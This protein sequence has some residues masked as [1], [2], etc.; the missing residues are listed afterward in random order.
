MHRGIRTVT[1][2]L[3]CLL[4]A[5]P[6]SSPVVEGKARQPRVAVFEL[7]LRNVKLKASM[8]GILRDYLADQVAQTG[9]YRVVP[10]DKTRAALNREQIQTKGLCFAKSCQIRIGRALAADRSLSTRVMRIGRNCTVSATLYN[11]ET[12]VTEKGASAKGGCG[13][14]A[15]Q[16][17]I[18]TVV[19][20]LTVKARTPSILQEQPPP[21]P[22]S[23]LRKGKDNREKNKE[24]GRLV[25]EGTPSGALIKLEGPSAFKGPANG[26]LPNDWSQI[27]PGSYKITV[28]AKGFNKFEA[29]S[30]VK[31][32]RTSVV[33]AQ[34]ARA[35]ETN[36]GETHTKTD[37][38]PARWTP[39]LIHK[40]KVRE[41]QVGKFTQS[42]DDEFILVTDQRE[43][44]QVTLEIVRVRNKQSTQIWQST[45]RGVLILPWHI[46][47][48]GQGNKM[49]FS[50]EHSNNAP[51]QIYSIKGEK[52]TKKKPMLTNWGRIVQSIQVQSKP[53]LL[54]HHNSS[55]IGCYYRRFNKWA[56]EY[57]K[58]PLFGRIPGPKKQTRDGPFWESILLA[59]IIP[60][61]N[62]KQIVAFS[63]VGIVGLFNA[64]GSQIRQE[65]IVKG[66]IQ[67]MAVKESTPRGVTE[68]W[69]AYKVNGKLHNSCRVSRYYYRHG[70]K[71]MDDWDLGD[72]DAMAGPRF[73]KERKAFVGIVRGTESTIMFLP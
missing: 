50:F 42:V 64:D 29:K 10:G 39:F 69:L 46:T 30:D 13:E 21:L 56:G 45:M 44:S 5:L 47:P 17:A 71:K 61:K 66:I 35:I 7:E 67:G 23:A 48:F 51:A 32:N 15:L 68:L 55:G 40:G 1:P 9:D 25:V 63:D 11:L 28:Y 19:R 16:V 65:K 26:S 33:V 54:V 24:L 38:R 37:R 52:I 27:P 31:S 60:A 34:L 8:A 43:V 41:F 20:K 57:H 58:C 49:L 59:D 62:N 22:K 36:D 14:E 12:Q 70:F 72:C 2:A 3:V 73:N 18:D 4:L 53:F 6:G